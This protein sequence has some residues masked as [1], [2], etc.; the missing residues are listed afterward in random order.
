MNHAQEQEQVHVHVAHN[1]SNEI[2]Q[3]LAKRPINDYGENDRD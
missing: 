2:F 1:A 3:W